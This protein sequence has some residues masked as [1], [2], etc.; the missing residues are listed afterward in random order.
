MVQEILDI[1]I[2]TWEPSV[3]I[4]VYR[5]SDY[6]RAKELIKIHFE[7]DKDSIEFYKKLE[8]WIIGEAKK[9]TGIKTVHSNA[10]LIDLEEDLR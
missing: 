7:S 2:N 5:T 4:T 6:Q 9:S 1:P 3:S 8:V 10:K